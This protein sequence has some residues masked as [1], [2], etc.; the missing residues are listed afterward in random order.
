MDSQS[1]GVGATRRPLYT[2]RGNTRGAHSSKTKEFYHVPIRALTF[3]LDDTLWAVEPVLQEAELRL[4]RWLTS[5]FPTVSRRYDAQAF[6]ELRQDIARTRPELSHNVTALR[7]ESL[8]VAALRCGC[9]ETL[10]E[11]AFDVFLTARNE[12]EF[13]ADTLPV[14]RRISTRFPIAAVTNGNA[15]I[16]RV[17]LGGYFAFSLSAPETGSAKPEPQMYHAA[18]TRL[19]ARPGEVVHVGD[20]PRSDV[21]GALAAGMRTVWLNRSTRPREMERTPNAEI[22]TLFE[23]EPVLARW[24]DAD[25][26]L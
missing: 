16:Q 10:V 20:D 24:S 13:Y 18:C 21:A 11:P 22:H 14:L 6:R 17:G 23:L 25:D 3:D 26:D 5:N 2:H 9:E 12:V 7:K 19:N 15:D 8:R 4:H 1:P